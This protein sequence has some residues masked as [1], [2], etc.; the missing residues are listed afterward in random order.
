M[1]KAFCKLGSL[2][3]IIRIFFLFFLGLGSK[4]KVL[5]EAGG[6]HFTKLRAPWGRII[7]RGG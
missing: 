3:V 1:Y 6:W 7:G 4:E 2:G 5:L